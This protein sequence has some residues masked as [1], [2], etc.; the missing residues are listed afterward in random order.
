MGYKAP[1]LAQLGLEIPNKL[2]DFHKNPGLAEIHDLPCLVDA[3]KYEVVKSVE[4][5]QLPSYLDIFPEARYTICVRPAGETMASVMEYFT[6]S[7]LRWPYNPEEA[8]KQLVR[9]A[10]AL[11]EKFSY[12]E[13][14]DLP[15]WQS[16]REPT[17]TFTSLNIDHLF[18]QLRGTIRR[19]DLS[20]FRRE[21]KPARK[22]ARK[23]ETS[24]SHSSG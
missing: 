17:K 14:K 23:L 11:P 3:K 12:I 22:K 1:T 2:K 21:D 7:G 10:T 20:D 8:T 13:V 9:I 24:T 6:I 15:E 19:V 18:D 5:H 4:L 16:D